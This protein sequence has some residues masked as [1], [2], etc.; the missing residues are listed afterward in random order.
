MDSQPPTGA[1]PPMQQGAAPG[2]QTPPDEAKELQDALARLADHPE[3]LELAAKLGHE[4]IRLQRFDEAQRITEQS[5][6]FDPFHVEHRI[7]RAVLR[8]AQGQS[9]QAI[10]ELQH[11]ATTYPHSEEARLFLGGLRMEIG[12][13]KGALEAFE[14]Y[15]AEAPP[16]DVPPQLPQVVGEL[17]SR[18]ASQGQP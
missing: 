17:K 18:V 1:R 9:Q 3:D 15:L 2:A 4:L 5:L 14:R 13:H 8:S 10:E 16:D 12:D 7:H 11:I 6:G